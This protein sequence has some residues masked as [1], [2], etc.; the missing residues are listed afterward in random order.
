MQKVKRNRGEILLKIDNM[1]QYL[2]KIDLKC[3][4]VLLEKMC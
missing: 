2:K 3:W 4:M 1:L